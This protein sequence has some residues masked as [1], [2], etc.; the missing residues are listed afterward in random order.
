MNTNINYND[1]TRK[2]TFKRQ[3]IASQLLNPAFF[4]YL[5]GLFFGGNYGTR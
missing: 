2:G 1:K 5:S 3:V 4:M